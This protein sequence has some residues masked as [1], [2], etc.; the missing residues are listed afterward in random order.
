ML[1][2]LIF[3]NNIRQEIEK[4][5][6]PSDLHM[7]SKLGV[8]KA[9]LEQP[10]RIL[11]TG[12]IIP[13]IATIFFVFSVGV[14][15]ATVPSFNQLISFINPQVALFLQPVERTSEDDGV[16]M[17]VVAALNDEEMAVVY[18]TMQDLT[19]NRIDSTL[20]LYDFELAGGHMLHSELVKYDE[21]NRT[22]TLRI[23]ANGGENLSHK[24]M[25]FQISSFLSNKQ[26][27]EKVHVDT[28]LVEL[29]NKMPQTMTLKMEAVSGNG[30]ELLEELQ[31]QKTIKILKPGAMDL[32]L[33]NIDFMHIT[34]L[35][36]IENR[37]HIQTKWTGNDVDSHGFFYLLDSSGNKINS[38]SISFGNDLNYGDDNIE[39]I[40][41]TNYL[42][43]DQLTLMADFVANGNYTEGNWSTTFQ[44]QS[45]GEEKTFEFKK[46]FETWNVDRFT[47][48]PLGITFYGK[49]EWEDSN[50]MAVTANMADGRVE[51]FDSVM[52]FS[53]N[54]KVKVKFLSPLPLDISK[55]KSIRINDTVIEL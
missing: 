29:K 48:S 8:R 12:T 26:F 34:N 28:N 19:G 51:T 35:G 23:Q 38:S 53:E 11:K 30:G 31:E 16:K 36:F 10:K 32:Y 9:R 15:A 1:R 55:M 52:S 47:I 13:L 39:Y 3:L 43:L 49:G 44:I 2:G 18:V 20:D 37:L 40:I 17:E 24:K 5:E 54:K 21:N 33:P 6:I 45:V 7:R 42:D 27:F 4:I 50:D 46:D 25:N 22:A 14:G 41:D